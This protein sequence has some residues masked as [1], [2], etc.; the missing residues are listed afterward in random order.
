MNKLFS[1]KSGPAPFIH[2]AFVV[3]ARVARSWKMGAPLA[4]AL[5]EFLRLSGWG[6]ESF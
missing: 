2:S 5:L 1:D 3:C 6:K 4:P